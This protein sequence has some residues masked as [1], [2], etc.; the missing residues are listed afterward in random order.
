M[1]RYHR[2]FG[3]AIEQEEVNECRWSSSRYQQQQQQ[4]QKKIPKQKDCVM[5]RRRRKDH[6]RMPLPVHF[7]RR[8][9]VDY[10]GHFQPC[11]PRELKGSDDLQTVRDRLVDRVLRKRQH[12][13][14]VHTQFGLR[15]YDYVVYT[16]H[17]KMYSV[18]QYVRS[19]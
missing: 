17:L 4:Q 15:I 19:L 12:I 10:F 9:S 16:L 14:Y 18:V 6:R 2:T 5:V 1:S 8:I 7:L 3:L 13:M 11:C